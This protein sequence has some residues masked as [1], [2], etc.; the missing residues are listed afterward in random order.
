[1]ADL[2]TEAKKRAVEERMTTTVKR[3]RAEAAAAHA[4]ETERKRLEAEAEA[5]R[6]A[7]AREASKPHIQR[8]FSSAMREC[9]EKKNIVAIANLCDSS[10]Q[11]PLFTKIRT[12]ASLLG[13]RNELQD[14][15]F[16][17]RDAC[18]DFPE[19]SEW[20]MWWHTEFRAIFWT[21]KSLKV[22]LE[23][24]GALAQPYL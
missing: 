11:R 6:V 8:L 9:A 10:F 17:W 22:T 7:R 1:M 23:E 14:E 21:P 20:S 18:Q 13:M 15:K 24:L 19:P 5:K 16:E 3:M 12:R 2:L 4:A